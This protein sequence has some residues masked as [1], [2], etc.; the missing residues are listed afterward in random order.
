MTDGWMDGRKDNGG[1][2]EPSIYGSPIFCI[3]SCN[4]EGGII[5][6][7]KKSAKVFFAMIQILKLFETLVF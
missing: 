5:I 2:I 4:S 1:F 3:L 7:K 6:I